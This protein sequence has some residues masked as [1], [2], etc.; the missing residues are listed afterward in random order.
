M[1]SVR[2]TIISLYGTSLTLIIF[3]TQVEEVVFPTFLKNDWSKRHQSKCGPING[4][5]PGEWSHKHASLAL[6]NRGMV[7]DVR[8]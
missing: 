6:R 4:Y 5:S 7:A 8:W 1:R 2:N 3:R